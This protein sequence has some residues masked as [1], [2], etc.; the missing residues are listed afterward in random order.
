MNKPSESFSESLFQQL[1]S[2]KKVLK[3]L[4]FE[5]SNMDKKDFSIHTCSTVMAIV[6]P[7]F[8]VLTNS[9]PF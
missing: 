9:N 5:K 6:D 3:Y 7:G 4:M 1:L 2:I 8:I